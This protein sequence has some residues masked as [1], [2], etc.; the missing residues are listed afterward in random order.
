LLTQKPRQKCRLR[1]ERL[2]G[3]SERSSFATAPGECLASKSGSVSP[4]SSV[5]GS[6]LPSSRILR[7]PRWAASST[8]LGA[9]RSR[10]RLEGLLG[11]H[12]VGWRPAWLRPAERRL[13]PAHAA[14]TGRAERG[15]R[16][17]GREPA[18]IA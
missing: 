11:P 7:R 15:G 5:P 8:V 2:V 1:L 13:L 14:P 3:G 16:G 12:G 9:R 4:P 18:R 17:S 6:S 10:R